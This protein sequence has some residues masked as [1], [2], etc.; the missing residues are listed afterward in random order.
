MRKDTISSKVAWSHSWPKPP[1]EEAVYRVGRLLFRAS[2]IDELASEEFELGK[3]HSDREGSLQRIVR[4]KPFPNAVK[5]AIDA[6]QAAMRFQIWS[7]Q[8]TYVIRW[9][10]AQGIDCH[11]QKTFDSAE[12][13][14]WFAD[15]FGD[16]EKSAIVRRRASV[17][18][19]F[20]T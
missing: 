11:S 10:Y 18:D 19:L 13:E 7:T 16:Y 4:G 14:K 12:F 2:W 9:L 20:K 8:I 6:A 15:K 5:D 3:Q 1:H 17:N